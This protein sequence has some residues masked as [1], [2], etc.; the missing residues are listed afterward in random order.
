MAK[1]LNKSL[2]DLVVVTLAKP[3]HDE[4]IIKMQRLGVKVFA[5]PDGDVAASVLTCLPESDID[6]MY[7]IGGAPEG[8]VT[9]AVMKALG[10]DMQGRLLPRHEVKELNDENIRHG[11]LELKRCEEM[12]VEARTVLTLEQMV[13]SDNVIF[14]ATGITKGDLLEGVSRKG[15][16]VTTETLLI[17][18]QSRTIRKISSTHH[19]EQKQAQLVC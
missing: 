19:I 12:G 8:V 13:K 18:G 14:A 4:I 15:N 17:Q 5:F 11:Q 1:A 16:V 2:E 7:C 6:L 3:R 9:A 10:G